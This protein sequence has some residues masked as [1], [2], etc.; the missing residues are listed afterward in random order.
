MSVAPVT[1]SVTVAAPPERAFEAFT[2]GFGDWWPRAYTWSQDVLEAIGI[3][4]GVGGV[5]F[6][7]GP[8]GL[9]CDWGRVLVWDPPARLAF[10]WQIGPDRV[11]VPDPD[12][13]SEVAVR[14]QAEGSGTR[15][16]LQ[17]RCFE[18]HGEAGAAYAQGMASEQGWPFILE[19]F[20]EHASR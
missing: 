5:C 6:E 16:D 8:H 12:R 19:R 4:P 13:C 15:V 1:A 18:R 3:E 10:T 11:P 2:S 20:A 7:R 14:F 9:R 17:H